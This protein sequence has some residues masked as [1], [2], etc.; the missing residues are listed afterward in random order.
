MRLVFA[1]T[2]E[3]ALPSLRR[4]LAS[5]RHEVVAVVTRLLALRADA[6]I[7]L[8]CVHGVRTVTTREPVAAGQNRPISSPLQAR[9]K[10]L[11]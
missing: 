9:R 6:N 3:P 5:G 2:P 7:D 11:K 4:L 1:G 10:F 8:H